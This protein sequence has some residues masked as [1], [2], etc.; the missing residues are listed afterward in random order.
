M[1]TLSSLLTDIEYKADYD[2]AVYPDGIDSIA[3]AS[4]CY[5]SKNAAA[6]SLFV[7]IS[8]ARAD[9]HDYASDAYSKGARIFVC[10]RY[11]HPGKDAVIITVGNSRSALSKIS[12]E[13]F[14]HPEKAEDNRNYRNK[15]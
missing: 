2:S 10:E 6:G 7:C 4:V 14:D 15:R 1:K 8:G 11:I 3:V 5:N 13:F 9:G 12:A